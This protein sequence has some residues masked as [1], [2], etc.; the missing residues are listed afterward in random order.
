MLQLILGFVLGAYFMYCWSFPKVK[1][2]KGGYRADII[3]P[4]TEEVELYYNTFSSCSQKVKVT[5]YIHI[6][7]DLLLGLEHFLGSWAVGLSSAFGQFK[8]NYILG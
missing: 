4:H 8:Y 1:S 7:A 5:F 6:L 2:V 3:L